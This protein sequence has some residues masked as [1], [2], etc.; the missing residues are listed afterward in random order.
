MSTKNKGF[1]IIEVL[2]SVTIIL[3]LFAIVISNFPKAKAQFA[4]SRVT[5]Q[6]AQDVSK[7]QNMAVS[8]VP[9][10]DSL[11][12]EQAVDGYGVYANMTSL[13]NKK[14]IIYADKN[15]GNSQYDG[16]DYTTNTIDFSSTEKGVVIKQIN[17]VS[18]N[19]A[20]VNFGSS[21]LATTI[22]ALNAGQTTVVFVFALESDLSVTKTV[23]INKSGLVEVK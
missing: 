12:V 11:G 15:P 14:Y 16:A 5:N 21:N 9:Y 1:T 3:S 10:K 8:A 6:F 2:V 18:G 13:G 7:A 22:T 23:V 19:I 4:L 17:N 20:S